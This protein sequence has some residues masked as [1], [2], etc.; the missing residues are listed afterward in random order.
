MTAVFHWTGTVD[1]LI[2][3]LIKCAMTAEYTGAAVCKNHAG[4]PSRPS[5]VWCNLSRSKK[6]R[7]SVMNGL[8]DETMLFFILITG[9]HH[10]R[11]FNKRYF[12]P[13]CLE[14]NGTSL[15]FSSIDI[16]LVLVR[17]VTSAH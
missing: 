3:R 15:R 1:C 9:Q 4:R 10:D 16:N 13:T 5:A 17:W 11:K 14:V 12:R 6:T 2:D 8:S 7:I